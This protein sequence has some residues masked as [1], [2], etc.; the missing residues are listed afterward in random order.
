[1]AEHS[2]HF[3]GLEGERSRGS[4]SRVVKG[5]AYGNRHRDTTGSHIPLMTLDKEL[6]RYESVNA[7]LRRYF[8]DSVATM[9]NLKSLSMRYVACALVW[10]SNYQTGGR[11]LTLEDI[12]PEIFGRTNI[13]TI[14]ALIICTGRPQEAL[15]MS[16][17]EEL[18]TYIYTVLLHR[19]SEVPADLLAS[20]PGSP[21]ESV[22]DEMEPPMLSP[23]APPV[24]QVI[25]LH[26]APLGAGSAAGRPVVRF[27]IPGR[28][29]RIGSPA[30]STIPSRGLPPAQ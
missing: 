5:Y 6:K 24:A 23:P 22:S 10:I 26:Q 4:K 20:V 27:D 3:L 12:T 11:L 1:M 25:P 7:D 9:E 21:V 14:R 15:T 17:F 8:K 30:V 2:K 13:I 29:T 18:F 28:A 16:D 19:N